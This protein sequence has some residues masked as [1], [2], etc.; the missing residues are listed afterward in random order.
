MC[1]DK[2]HFPLQFKQAKVIPIFKSGDPQTPSNY[3]PISILSWLTKPLEKHINKHLLAHFEKNNLLHQDQSGFRAN[4]SCHT[5]L[6][7]LIEKCYYNI[8]NNEFTGLLFV[9]FAKAFDVIN[10]SLLLKKLTLYQLAPEFLE[11]IASFLAD[12]HQQVLVQTQISTSLPVKFG[13]P[14]GS[15][16]GPILFSIYI[17]DLPLYLSCSSEIFADDTTLDSSDKTPENLVCKLQMSIAELTNWTDLN[18]MSL[19]PDKTKCMYATSRQKRN[20]MYNSFPPLYIK[21]KIV[22]EVNHHKLLGVT[23]D[24]NLL[25]TE[26]VNILG[27]QL[28]RKIHQ[29]SK[30][31]H[32]LDVNSRKTFFHAH[33][34][35]IIDYASTIWDGTSETN[36][37]LLSKLYKRALKYILLKSSSLTVSDY[38][39]LDILPLNKRLLFNKYIFMHKVMH[40]AAPKKVQEKFSKNTHRHTHLLTFPRPRNNMFK[41]SFLYSGS[42]LWN[43]LPSYLKS[44]TGKTVFKTAIK[45]FLQDTVD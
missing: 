18:H 21:D 11:L 29:L 5:A 34:L 28:S 24:N 31:K 37:K 2:N 33:I 1:I 41:S 30:I 45:K 20:K 25:W 35:S 32:F 43:N 10:H 39:I 40:G 16:L 13:V 38:K 8:N 12:R 27:K 6:T 23:I 14:Q 22:T 7:Q 3:R 36:L 15:I 26:H 17:N 44:V 19:N 4:H 9:D 42:T